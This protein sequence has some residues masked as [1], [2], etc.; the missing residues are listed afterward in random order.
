MSLQESTLY[1]HDARRIH[2]HVAR[3]SP[4]SNKRYELFSHDINL[5]EITDKRRLR[6]TLLLSTFTLAD[7][8]ILASEV[9]WSI[10]MNVDRPKVSKVHGIAIHYQFEVQVHVRVLASSYKIK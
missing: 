8:T 9:T 3:T 5:A 10:E 6:I 1:Y 7:S 4:P 2:V